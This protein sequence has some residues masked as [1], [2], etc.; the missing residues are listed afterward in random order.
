MFALKFTI[1]EDTP[2]QTTDERE[3]TH[4][5]RRRKIIDLDIFRG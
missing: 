3:N 4:P 5:D 1:H 2:L